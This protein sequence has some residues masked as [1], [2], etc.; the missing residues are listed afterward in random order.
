[1]SLPLEGIR[2]IDVSEHG[3][4][5][6]AGAT[7]ADFGADVIKIER[8]DGDACRGI[9]ASGMVPTKDGVDYLFEIFNRNKRGIGL[10]ISS[11]AGQAVLARL[12]ESA[13][14]F[15]TNQLPQIQRKFHTTVE[16]IQAINPRIVYARGHGQGQRGR[17]AEVG[18]FDSVS[19][20]ARGGLGHLLS[21]PDV[22]T[23]SMQRAA[24]G[25]LPSGTFLVSGICAALVR[26]GRT[27][28]GGV[29]DASLLN[30]AVWTIGP[31][32]AYTSMTG[33]QLDS[34]GVI[35]SPLT[36]T[37][38][39]SDG[40]FVMLMMINEDRYWTTATDALGMTELGQ[41]YADPVERRAVWP[42]LKAPF[43]EAIARLSRDEI[44]TRLS[45]GSCIFSFFATP[46]EVLADQAVLD[47]G[48]LMQHPNYD[49]L[50]IAAS[51]VQFENQFPQIRRGAPKL[52]EHS[53]ELLEELGYSSDDIADLLSG[54]TVVD[55]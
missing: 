46:S 6:S 8:L 16:E 13:D 23:P 1:V 12:I 11:A 51:P 7:L 39:T 25:D 14:V 34:S 4:V 37:Y 27:G 35:R 30:S 29:V 40:Y 19:Y 43:E 38:R 17:D 5:P 3:F 49:S 20:W 22:T 10:D 47:N 15:L 54:G 48:Y 28:E 9:I 21:P 50:K 52:G 41:K 45:E 44:R 36:H 32:L 53:K 31:D 24:T 33:T 26:A 18:G 2:V 55:G 42:E